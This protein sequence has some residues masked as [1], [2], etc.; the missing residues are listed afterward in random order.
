MAIIMDPKRQA[1][2]PKFYL[3]SENKVIE[4]VLALSL[5]YVKNGV[6]VDAYYMNENVSRRSVRNSADFEMLYGEM[7]HYSFREDK[8]TEGF[9]AK[10][11]DGAYLSGAYKLIFVLQSFGSKTAEWIDTIN[12]GRLPVVVYLIDDKGDI[13]AENIDRD[14]SIVR[15][16]TKDDLVE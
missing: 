5:Y 15:I 1:P 6:P 8:A 14:I 3:P 12:T 13:S 4:V 10:L 7:L 16:G 2:D 9:L 11:Y